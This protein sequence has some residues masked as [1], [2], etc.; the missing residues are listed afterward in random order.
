[1]NG[2]P[3]TQLDLMG[4]ADGHLDV[5]RRQ[6]VDRLLAQRADLLAMTDAI[7]RQNEVL[8]ETYGAVL[9]E[10]VPERLLGALDEPKPG[11]RATRM[12]RIAAVAALAIV[13]SVAG[14]WGGQLMD[15]S[16]E[17]ND[18]S[19]FVRAAASTHLVPPDPMARTL[20]GWSLDANAQPLEWLAERVTLE[21]RAPSLEGH[22]YRSMDKALVEIDGRPTVKLMF[23]G[24]EGRMVSLFLRTRWDETPPTWNL[25]TDAEHPTVYW[26]DGPL[27]WVLI[28][29]VD[30]ATL[31]GLAEVIHDT[32]RLRP[33]ATGTDGIQNVEADAALGTA[34]TDTRPGG[35]SPQGTKTH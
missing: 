11:N 13:T 26:F 1:M 4:Y 30:A 17:A 35:V 7:T 15:R 24:D 14:W 16:A 32:A 5:A 6:H 31:T 3:V 29:D 8:R 22:G 9:D 18:V 12:R 20:S 21:L 33:S 23:E 2:S 10:P 27:M 25:E 19:N 34:H 28:G